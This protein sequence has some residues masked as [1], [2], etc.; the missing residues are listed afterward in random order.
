MP[1]NSP[2][3]IVTFIASLARVEDTSIHL[4]RGSYRRAER[5]IRA[6]NLT[7]LKDGDQIP[8]CGAL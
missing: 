6:S 7:K 2:F 8:L 4:G 5:N 1:G 3:R